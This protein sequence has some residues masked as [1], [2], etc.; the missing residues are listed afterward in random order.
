MLKFVVC[1]VILAVAYSTQVVLTCRTND[2]RRINLLRLEVNYVSQEVE[3]LKNQSTA[4]QQKEE[5]TSLFQEIEALKNQSKENR[6]FVLDMFS[7]KL[8]VSPNYYTYQLTPGRQSWQQSREFCQNWGGDLAVYG[9]KTLENRKKLNQM[10][11]ISSDFWIGAND[12]ASEGNWVW[13]NGN[14]ASRSELIWD[15][16]QPQNSGGG[17]DCVSVVGNPSSPN[18]GLAHDYPCTWLHR[19]LCEKE[20]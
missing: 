11:S 5:I 7:K 17:E 18:V 13:A 3:A 14:R 16:G 6:Q 20:S 19:G 4:N 1:I 10:M 9:V 8:Y 12:I 15:R 2:D